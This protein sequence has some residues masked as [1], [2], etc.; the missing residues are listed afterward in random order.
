MQC[1]IF[2]GLILFFTQMYFYECVLDAPLFKCESYLL[3]VCS[4][5]PI[6]CSCHF[7]WV[8]KLEWKLSVCI[9]SYHFVLTS[10]HLLFESYPSM[11]LGTTLT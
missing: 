6:K 1:T 2:R 10:F 5:V 11:T 3:R 4:P 7:L 9:E 8:V